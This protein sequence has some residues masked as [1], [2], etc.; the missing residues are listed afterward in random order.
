M[1]EIDDKTTTAHLLQFVEMPEQGKILFRPDDRQAG[2]VIHPVCFT[3]IGDHRPVG[4]DAGQ[5]NP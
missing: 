2:P 1:G 3:S 4:F 5:R